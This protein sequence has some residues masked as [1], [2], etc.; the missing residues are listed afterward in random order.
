MKSENRSPSSMILTI[1][2]LRGDKQ[3]IEG[4]I[5]LKE[6]KVYVLKSEELRIDN[7]VIL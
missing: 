6:G 5:V 1:K 2:V 3:Q 4:E 7:L